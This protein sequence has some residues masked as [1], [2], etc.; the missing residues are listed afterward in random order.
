MEDEQ[1]A[2]ECRLKHLGYELSP[3]G[4]PLIEQWERAIA[5]GLDPDL[6]IDEDEIAKR[7]DQKIQREAEE[8]YQQTGEVLYKAPLHPSIAFVEALREGLNPMDAMLKEA[9]EERG[10]R[11]AQGAL[12]QTAGA[13]Q[14]GHEIAKDAALALND[15][16]LESVPREA[17]DSFVSG[18]GL[19]QK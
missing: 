15:K 8:H 3:G 4:D 10:V 12:Q 11:S 18:A 2:R 7:R 9:E 6:D 5:L 17:F 14:Q 16:L 19:H 13:T 1:K